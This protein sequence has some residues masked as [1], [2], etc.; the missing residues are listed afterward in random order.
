M[1]MQDKYQQ[2][3]LTKTGNAKLADAI[4][5]VTLNAGRWAGYYLGTQVVLLRLGVWQEV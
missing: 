2:V 3:V 5:R 1:R 4:I